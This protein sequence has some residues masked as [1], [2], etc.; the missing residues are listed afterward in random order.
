MNWYLQSNENCDVVRSTRIRF[1]RN[2]SEF[3][4]DLQSKEELE[5]LEN[6]IKDNL[7]AIGYGTLSST[8]RRARE[9]I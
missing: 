8:H 9:G 5:N 2:L 1:A 4:F 6:K 3:K 7:Y